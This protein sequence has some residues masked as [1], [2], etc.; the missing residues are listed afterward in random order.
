MISARLLNNE[1]GKE[2][3][4]SALFHHIAVNQIKSLGDKTTRLIAGSLF[5]G[6]ATTDSNR[7][8]NRRVVF[9]LTKTETVSAAN[10][11]R[12]LSSSLRSLKLCLRKIYPIL[13]IL[14]NSQPW[15]QSL[16]SPIPATEH[17]PVS[18]LVKNQQDI[19]TM[20]ITP[21]PVAA[22]GWMNLNIISPALNVATGYKN[23]PTV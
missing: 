15:I 20:T 10:T 16:T 6:L 21:V 12:P 18:L 19:T 5:N 23:E 13:G 1:C 9:L 17:D 22:A 14:L 8:S 2:R 4:T 7:R 3:G 11:Y